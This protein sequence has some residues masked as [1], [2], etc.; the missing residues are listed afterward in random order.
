MGRHLHT[1]VGGR[2]RGD[3]D[4]SPH[5]WVQCTTPLRLLATGENIRHRLD[6]ADAFEA[7]MVDFAVRYGIEA[8]KGESCAVLASAFTGEHETV[9]DHR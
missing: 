6:L 2:L 9:E 1:S 5:G 7:L 3:D 4:E 8:W